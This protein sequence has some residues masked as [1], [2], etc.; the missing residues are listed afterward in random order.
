MTRRYF[1]PRL[2]L[3]G[4]AVELSES[5]SQHASRVMR[6]SAGDR[7][8]LFDGDGHEAEA[9]VAAI[10]KRCC[11][12]LAAAAVPIDR[13]P[14]CKLTL[15]VA[16]PKPDRARELVERL[17][18]LGVNSMVPLIAERT[19]R[20]PSPSLIDKLRR[21][22]IEASKQCG[23]NRLM[24]I[25]SPQKSVT[26]FEQSAG[27]NDRRWIAAPGGGPL[28]EAKNERELVRLLAAV[29]PEGGWTPGELQ[30]AAES[31]FQQIDLGKRIYRI[32]TAAA[33]IAAVL[34]D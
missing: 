27:G 25:E 22:V 3:A 23:R 6:V 30:A 14:T 32:E 1:V 11:R 9:E 15:A 7:I 16:L 29:G 18:E 31:G 19:Q 34:A 13:E 10:D 20:P 24:K 33:V 28:S 8:T 12:C 4:G 5:E 17:T 2:P 26:F 21:G